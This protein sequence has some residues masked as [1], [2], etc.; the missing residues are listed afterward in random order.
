ML[1]GETACAKEAKLLQA[2]SYTPPP[3]D[4]LLQQQQAQAEA[5][6]TN[7]LQHKLQGDTA[8]IL[9][10]YGTLVALTGNGAGASLTSA[11]KAS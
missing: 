3:P 5:E 1:F 2:P 8:S 7:A 11:V 9:S 6:Q 10:R 4:P